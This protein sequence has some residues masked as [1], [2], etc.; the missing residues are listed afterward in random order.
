[1]I[2]NVQNSFQLQKRLKNYSKNWI[3][4]KFS[5]DLKNVSQHCWGHYIIKTK[6]FEDFS[7]RVNMDDRSALCSVNQQ[8][9]LVGDR[10]SG[11]CERFWTCGPYWEMWDIWEL[12]YGNGNGNAWFNSDYGF[13]RILK[14]KIDSILYFLLY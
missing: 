7:N 10:V 14:A 2:W 13:Y 1:M 4:S 12:C 11:R 8:P 6:H 9:T 5:N 3:F